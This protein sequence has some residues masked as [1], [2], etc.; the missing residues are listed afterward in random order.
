[1]KLCAK[2]NNKNGRQ[3]AKRALRLQSQP[4]MEMMMMLGRMEDDDDDD[5]RKLQPTKQK[6]N[7]R[8]ISRKAERKR[9]AT[10]NETVENDGIEQGE[11]RDAKAKDGRGRTMPVAS[12]RGGRWRQQRRQKKLNKYKRKKKRKIIRKKK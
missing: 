4:E 9:R 2:K 7:R 5:G 1:M 8:K 12:G 3:T 10:A 11:T 6:K